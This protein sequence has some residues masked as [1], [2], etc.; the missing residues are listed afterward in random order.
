MNLGFKTRIYLGAGL[1]VAI[2]LTVL[3]TLNIMSLKQK[4]THSLVEMTEN[5][6]DYH[7]TSLEDFIRF[8]LN[9]I[10]KGAKQFHARLP[11]NESQELVSVLADTAGIDNVTM[12]YTDGRTFTSSLKK[13]TTDLRNKR[14]FQNA[15]Q[16]YQLK[17]TDIYLNPTLNQK[18]VG[19]VMPV[20]DN[21]RLIGVLLGEIQLSDIITKVS[22][23]RFAGGAATLTD[24]N[25]VFFASD[26]P[27]DIGRTPSQISPDFAEMERAF[28]VKQSGHLSFPYLGRQF[29]GYFQRVHLTDSDYWTL[30]VFIDTDTALQEVYS[31]QNEA[32]I[33][34][35]ILILIS[36]GAIFLIVNH[37]FRPLIKLKSAV[38]ELSHGTGDL[39]NR[40]EVDGTDDLAMISQGFNNFI[41][42]L[43]NMM[44]QISDASQNISTNLVQ[45][46][47]TARENESKLV[48]HSGETEQVV[49]AITEMSQSARTVADNVLQS[50]ELTDEANQEAQS[51]LLIVNDAVASVTSL[52]SEVEDMSSRISRMHHDANK[53]SDVLNVIGDISEQTNLLALNAAIEAARAG[54]QG[55]GFA[56][57]A[58][59][60]RALAGRTQ[61]STTEIS[62]MLSKL[63]EGTDSVVRAMNTTKEQCQS[64]ADKTSEVSVSL[65]HMSESV[66][67]VDEVSTQISSATNEQSQVAETL[68]QNMLSIQ[69]IVDSLVVSGKQTVAATES[70]SKSNNELERLV[71]NFKLH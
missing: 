1:L 43:Q 48:M 63:L 62:D 3:G 66:T 20:R 46:G 27:S 56:V 18:V 64:T 16:D 61:Q 58:D 24:Q 39:T 51:S 29:D 15:S 55:R 40:L 31:A 67:Q 6:L 2:S 57:V 71:A 42:N 50:N 25:A 4:M 26:D 47:E 28:S 49:T 45:L 32:I 53:I 19:A 21:G 68:N 22:E 5:K 33:T 35:I 12:V 7:V 44:L 11:D 59:E 36:I 23:M 69:D 10:S 41:E 60:V 52:V 54:E 14:W 8:Q 37:A 17:L 9:A 38:I 30:M 70:L 65:K 34:S 13:E